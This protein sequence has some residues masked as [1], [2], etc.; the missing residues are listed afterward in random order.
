MPPVKNDTRKEKNCDPASTFLKCW[1]GGLKRRRRA[2]GEVIE[3]VVLSHLTER[4]EVLE[5]VALSHLTERKEKK[6]KEKERG[7]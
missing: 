3:G 6:R 1:L 4:K 2:I 7:L 5:R